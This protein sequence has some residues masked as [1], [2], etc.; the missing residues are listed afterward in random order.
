MSDNLSDFLTW[1]DK[2]YSLAH[3]VRLAV[4]EY[5]EALNNHRVD[6]TERQAVDAHALLN[7]VNTGSVPKGKVDGN[8]LKA[9][10]REEYIRCVKRPARKLDIVESK[11]LTRFAD[12]Y[13]NSVDCYKAITYYMEN[14]ANLKYLTGFPTIRALWGFKDTLMKEALQGGGKRG[15]FTAGGDDA[16]GF[17]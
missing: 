14:Y 13:H 17:G 4:E 1:C 8:K 12:A 3:I 2:H 11:L 16:S 7:A 5:R 6:A 10:W 9:F 15:Q